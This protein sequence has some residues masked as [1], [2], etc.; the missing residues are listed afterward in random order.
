M[1]QVEMNKDVR[2]YKEKLFGPLS[3]RETLCIV[4]GC[5]TFFLVK[6]FIF[7]NVELMSDVS[8]FLFLICFA[9]FGIFGWAKISGMYLN[10]YFKLAS[11]CLLA[12]KV[13]HYDNGLKL[14][15]K[16]IKT[17]PSKKSEL[18]PFK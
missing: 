4:C 2:A 3:G 8:G 16:A 18:K 9:P 12:P 17:K 1:I 14:K 15:R 10:E 6:T 11:K 13:R 5:A 7:A